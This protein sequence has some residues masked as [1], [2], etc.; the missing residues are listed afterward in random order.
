MILLQTLQ[1]FCADDRCRRKILIPGPQFL[2]AETSMA[3]NATDSRGR[4]HSSVR[5]RGHG[6]QDLG[7]IAY[8]ARRAWAGSTSAARRAGMAQAA[9]APISVKSSTLDHVRTSS[10]VTP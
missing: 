1:F 3:L 6:D 2:T 9:A 10:G 7:T 5:S 4:G 8:P